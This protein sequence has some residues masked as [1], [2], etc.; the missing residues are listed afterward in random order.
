E[1]QVGWF[2]RPRAD[3]TG[4]ERGGQVGPW[5]DQAEAGKRLYVR[6]EHRQVEGQVVAEQAAASEPVQELAYSPG[7]LDARG[8]LLGRDVVVP[9]RFDAEIA[10]GPDPAFE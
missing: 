2:G 1:I 8:G 9:G 3:R 6:V 10:V 4:G 5:I 7:H